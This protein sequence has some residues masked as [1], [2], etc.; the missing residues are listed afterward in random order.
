MCRIL[1]VVA[2]FL[3]QL[4][5]H[6]QVI[7]FLSESTGEP[8]EGVLIYSADERDFASSDQEG[9][10]DVHTFDP[11]SMLIFRHPSFH[12]LKLPKKS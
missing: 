7:R 9:M 5:C 6:A 8:V 4:S 1:L 11:E 12:M 10:V 2:Y 3:V